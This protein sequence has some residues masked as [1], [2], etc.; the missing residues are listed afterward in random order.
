MNI[1]SYAIKRKTV[2]IALTLAF[3]ISGFFSY[4]DLPRLEDP[5]FT[6]KQALV[7]TSYSGASPVQVEE[8]VTDILETAIQKMPQ[9]KQVTSVSQ[10]GRSIITVSMQEHFDKHSLPDVWT[11]LRAK[12]S[13]AA[14]NL[15]SGVQ[16]PRVIDDFGDVYGFLYALT[17][18]GFS[19][20]EI[21]EYAKHLR[22][23]ILLM[24]GVGKV[25]LWGVQQEAIYI[26]VSQT[27]LAAVNRN[28]NDLKG[29]LAAQ[30]SIASAG[31]V[32]VGSEYVRIQSSNAINA[33]SDL[34][35]LL[36]LDT[37]DTAVYL[38]DVAEVSREYVEPFTQLMRINGQAAIGLAISTASGANVVELGHDIKTLLNEVHKSIPIGL[39][40]KPVVLQDEAVNSAINGFI[41]SLLQAVLIVFIV[42]LVF[43]G[44]R[45]GFIIGFVL[46]VT[47]VI[48]FSAMQ[49]MGLALERISLG[50]LIIALGML[51]DNAIVVCEGM[52]TRIKQGEDRL[53]SAVTVV[54]QNQWPL[55]GAT[56]IAILAFSAIGLSE[57]A[58]GEYCRSLFL[59]ILSSL[60]ISWVVALTL[61]PLLCFWLLPDR[62]ETSQHSEEYDPYQSVFFVKYRQ[63]LEFVLR[64]RAMTLAVALS[65]LIASF[66]A[67]GFVQKAFFPKSTMP[68]FMVHYW[69]PEGTDIRQ[70]SSDVEQLDG[71]LGSLEGVSSVT[72]FVGDGAPR[73][74]LV[75]SP[76]KP[77]SSYGMLLV[78][79]D[80]YKKVDALIPTVARYLDQHFLDAEPKI[81][82]F[83][84]GPSPQSS[85]EVRFSGEDELVLRGLAEQVK[86]ILKDANALSVRD[87]WRQRTKSIEPIFL[88][89]Q[90]SLVDVS[91]SDLNS[92]LQTSYGGSSVG[93]YR[94]GNDLLPIY[95]RIKED[96]ARDASDL[97][98]IQVWSS[99]SSTYVPVSQVVE[100]FNIAW[101]DSLIQRR[102]RKRTITIGAEPEF[103]VLPSY[104]FER[105]KEEV[106]TI[107]LPAGY[108]RSW[109]GEHESS[110]DAQ[111]S[112][113][114]GIAISFVIMI[115]ISILLFNSLRQPAIIWA[116][117]PF[118]LAGVS[119]GLLITG[120]P[121][122]FM[123]LLGFLS[124]SG[125][126]IKN[127][128]VLLEQISIEEQEG[129]D[130]YQATLNAAVSR[131]R[132][133]MLAAATTV[134]GMIPLLSDAFFSAMAVAIMAGLSVASILTLI[135]V[136]VLFTLAYSVKTS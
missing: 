41:S 98:N 5:E 99:R 84:L 34:E 95:S 112:L 129:R 72:S 135:L 33:V 103:G 92:A 109:G 39:E 106:D 47:V 94:E 101:I 55:L 70:T 54:K 56:C 100:K 18:D 118:S 12:V 24:D 86:R 25:D 35:N 127:V 82:K 71:W 114:A 43:M 121:F 133:V 38:K 23:E 16:Q 62:D 75:Y 10:S 53:Y 15:P 68:Y 58:V 81:Q 93:V 22:N 120:L 46:V 8:Q 122:G 104:L 14:V 132:P 80:D 26:D 20:K 61:T 40:A 31:H 66:Y 64:H 111:Q 65:I 123:A 51:V 128:I 6:I 74:V 77:N 60:T 107:V 113:F 97:M 76:E 136:P 87:S 124:L 27:Q 3:V 11:I 28:I 19:Q 48:T 49:V 1:A 90:A 42:L 57:E 134:L 96:G 73:F 44:L 83:D 119:F 9:V 63:V 102:D 59:V 115:L 37:N 91:R 30:D 108:E 126:L 52:Q 17:G 32:K 89:Q 85:I 105:V 29:F 131:V 36:V 45:A 88:E 13:D 4:I 130:K 67:F 69:L 110:N 7:V 78:K 117:V 125:M 21:Y 79:V 116:V 2:T 50:A